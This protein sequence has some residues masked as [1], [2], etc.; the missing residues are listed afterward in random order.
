MRRR[1]PPQ[2]SR[3]AR[4]SIESSRR[5]YLRDA[6]RKRGEANR[7]RLAAAGYLKMVADAQGKVSKAEVDLGKARAAEQKKRDDQTQRERNKHEAGERRQRAQA[8]RVVKQAERERD[9][10]DQTRQRADAMRDSR[11]DYLS[12]GIAAVRGDVDATREVLDAQPW[13][14]V[15]QRITILIL[16]AEPDDVDR[17]R[18]DREIREIQEQVRSSD[19]RDSIVFQY[20]PATRFIDL[21]QHLNET[22]PDVVHFSGHGHERGIALHDE[23]DQL[24]EMTNE[25]LGGLLAVAPKPLK[26]VV[27]NSCRSAEQ[28]R[29][30]AKYA[31]AAIGMQESIGD[32]V[33]R[34]F[35]GQL[36]NSLGF[37]RSLGLAMQQAML[38]VEMKLNRTS[39]EPTLVM[40]NGLDPGD[41]IVVDPNA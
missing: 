13:E 31:A 12:A 7:A 3:A 19:L 1:P 33:A 27:F 20:R 29:V 10:A 36:Y 41:F 32:E 4:T 5:T 28:A 26:L 39:A 16:T 37:G 24:R 18:I 40:A 14:Y 17:L 15:S 23:H 21:I 22:E 8:A 2:R 11:I 9:R 38:F 30:A 34:V 25:E 35:A 6:E